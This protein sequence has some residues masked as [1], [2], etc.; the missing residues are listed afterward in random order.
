[1]ATLSREGIPVARG[2]SFA[3][4]VVDPSAEQRAGIQRAI[5][6]FQQGAPA[7]FVNGMA[8]SDPS[9]T[10]TIAEYARTRSRR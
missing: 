8:M 10:Q 7:V 5:E 9:A 4:D 1:V 3:F 2:S 6:V